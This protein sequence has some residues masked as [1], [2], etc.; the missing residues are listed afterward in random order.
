MAF[1]Q[2]EYHKHYRQKNKK[3]LAEYNRLWRL[4][5]PN[6]MKEHHKRFYAKNGDAER[7]RS[8]KNYEKYK[9]FKTSDK[10]RRVVRELGHKCVVCGFSEVINV[11]HI[12]PA[13]KYPNG[14]RKK[15]FALKRIDEYIVL[16]PNHHAL[17]HMGKISPEELK[18]YKERVSPSP[19][20]EKEVV[21]QKS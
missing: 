9:Q 17:V 2:E 14:K 10:R 21:S 16:C 19:F 5:H 12:V 6:Y 20:P 3:K 7:E 1:D 13:R 15:D 4:R 8:S 18:S 11:H